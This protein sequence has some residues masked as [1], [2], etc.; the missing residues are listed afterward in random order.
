MRLVVLGATGGTGQEVVRQAVEQGHRVTALVRTPESLKK[1]G[2]RIV[3]VQ[4][5]LLNL[6]ELEQVTAGHDAVLSGF[7]P[8]L[9]VSRKDASL[10]RQFAAGLTGAMLNTGVR[11]LV[12]VSVAF[13]FRNSIIPPAYLLGRLFFPGIVADAAAMEKVME[14]SRLDWTIVRPP[15]LTDKSLTRKYRVGEGHL[16]RF[17]F[18]ISRAD[19]ADFM[20]KAVKDQ[21]TVG[22]IFGV[23][24]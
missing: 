9:P 10:L 13:L 17:G 18:S 14:Q 21:A 20:L 2:H 15:K 12:I 8:R 19:V 1:L 3:V 6:A 4:G 7:G 22:K 5:D 16:P 23:C 24:N 11:R